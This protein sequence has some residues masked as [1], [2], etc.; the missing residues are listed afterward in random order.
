VPQTDRAKSV[1]QPFGQRLPELD[2]LR[3]IAVLL[4]FGA[5]PA[6]KWPADTLPI[7]PARVWF[8]IG[9]SGVDLFFVLSGFLVAGLLFSDYR[10]HGTIHLKSFF[11]RRGLRIWPAY[12]LYVAY[13]AILLAKFGASWGEFLPFVLHFQNY[14]PAHET[15][16][17]H[18]WSLAVE[19]HF[20]LLLPLV[21]AA[22]RRH[23]S[24]RSFAAGALGVIVMC[25][26]L[27]VLF[28]PPGRADPVETHYRLDG[29]TIGVFLAYVY[30]FHGTL[31]WRLA[32]T[33]WLLMPAG[34][35]LVLFALLPGALRTI[36]P[37]RV[38]NAILLPTVYAG[39]AAILLGALSLGRDKRSARFFDS[40]LLR[41]MAA[42]GTY[43]YSIYLWHLDF[44]FRFTSA[45]IESRLFVTDLLWLDWMV[46]TGLYIACACGGG[47]LASSCVEYPMLVL[48]ERWFPSHGR[49]IDAPAAK[50]ARL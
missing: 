23:W 9:R 10:K 15:Y 6:F 44:G 38:N 22:T 14:T 42:I 26:L 29:L 28:C 25:A 7:L 30:H 17:P 35:A 45:I 8:Q 36:V 20:Y 16:A 47:V 12:Y 43:S 41:S 48:R 40:K 31:F 18:L 27:R 49:A 32:R 3:C 34:A 37:P 11:A 4:V 21:L 33:G 24:L 13:L 1:P 5:H 46:H 50:L 2:V 19:E 39:Y